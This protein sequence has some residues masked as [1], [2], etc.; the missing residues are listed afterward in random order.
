VLLTGDIEA[1]AERALIQRGL[2]PVAD[3][4]LIPHHGSLTSSSRPF[5]NSTRP[6]LAI[7]STGYRNRWNL[8]QQRVTDRWQSA[9]AEVLDTA[10]SGAISL[11]LC[12]VGGIRW[13]KR[14]RQ[15]RRRFWHA[16]QD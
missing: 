13:L 14:W 15:Q 4:V 8:P 12:H 10:T 7:V 9:G 1:A 6:G 16:G 11:S 5:V 2:L 3:V